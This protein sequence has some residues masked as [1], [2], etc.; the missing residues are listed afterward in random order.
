[1]ILPT[2]DAFAVTISAHLTADP[3]LALAGH[4]QRTHR[5]ATLSTRL[6]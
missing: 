1:V 6:R 5:G 2:G 3:A 4:A